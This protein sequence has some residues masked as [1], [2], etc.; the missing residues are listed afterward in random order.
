MTSYG[1][2]NSFNI[3]DSTCSCRWRQ[4]MGIPYEHGV[5]TLGLA[6]LGSITRVFEYFR[7]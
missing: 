7:N 6:N 4:T 5:R 1:K 2:T 3:E